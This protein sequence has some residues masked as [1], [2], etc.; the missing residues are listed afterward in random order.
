MP[1]C[2]WIKPLIQRFIVWA[3]TVR[4]LHVIVI[5]ASF[6]FLTWHLVYRVIYAPNSNANS[7]IYRFMSGQIMTVISKRLKSL[8]PHIYVGFFPFK[9]F[10]WNVEFQPLVRF[11]SANIWFRLIKVTTTKTKLYSHHFHMIYYKFPLF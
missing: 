3:L 4:T 7:I 9:K 6:L 1:I 5:Q 8:L 2:V 10:K 11:Y